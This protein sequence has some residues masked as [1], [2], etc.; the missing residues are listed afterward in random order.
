MSLANGIAIIKA[1]IAQ[2]PQKAGIYK[3]L[4]EDGEHLYI[5]KAKNL[6][7]RVVSYTRADALPYRLQRMVSLTAR[8]EFTI[9]KSETEA[10]LLEATQ[11]KDLKPR[12]NILLRD[13]KSFPYILLTDDLE[14][15]MLLKHRGS[16]KRKGEYFGPFISALAVNRTLDSLQKAFPLRSC[17]DAFFNARTK[18]CLEYQIKRCTA[19]CVGKIE[20]ADYNKIVGEA[21]AFLRGK[22]ADIQARLAEDM[23]TAAN[24]EEFEKAAVIRNRIWALSKIQSD[25]K[26]NF[27]PD[28][29][30]D[31]IVFCKEAEKV[32]MHLS[33]IRNGMNNG[34]QSFYPDNMPEDDEEALED[35][36]M[37]FY[38]I[39]AA[40][41]LILLNRHLENSEVVEQALSQISGHKV[42]I[43]LPVRGEKYALIKYANIAA[44]ENLQRKLAESAN[45]KRFLKMAQEQFAMAKMPERIEVYDNSHISGTNAVGAM[46]VATADGFDKKSYRKFNIQTTKLGDDYAMMREVFSRRFRKGEN[47]PDL[48]LIDGGKGQLSSVMEAI[49]GLNEEVNLGG[50][51]FVA[52]SKGEE[53]N[54]GREEYHMVGRKPFV[55]EYR[56]ELAFFLQ[57]IRDEAH[58]FAIAGHRAKRSKDIQKSE[59]IEIGGIGGKRKKD[60]LNYFGSVAAIKDANVADLIMVQGISAKTAQKIY[61]SFH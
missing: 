52:I 59:L 61:D 48:V 31:A 38:Q 20:P 2:M 47:L 19:P 33:F 12:F 29:N 45:Q 46:I 42:I 32:C 36:I 34:N 41:K 50:V 27:S 40:P 5:G 49:N 10:L 9:V 23:Q 18:P 17:S 25:Q 14:Y 24:A 56:S 4:S 28:T 13:D 43:E 44:R 21:R 35:F 3:M 26:L 39:H 15:N 11:V 22:T 58:R 7:K 51:T 55:I 60:L 37:Q 57:R 16:M 8:M 30:L 53:R 6:P 1:A 54:A